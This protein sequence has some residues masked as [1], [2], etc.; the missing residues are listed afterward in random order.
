MQQNKKLICI[1]TLSKADK[2]RGSI[3]FKF[4]CLPPTRN[5][6]IECFLGGG[7]LKRWQ[8]KQTKKFAFLLVTG[9]TKMIKW[10]IDE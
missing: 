7:P 10:N 5:R 6:R 1:L 3:L 9:Y 8:Q 2:V 4:V